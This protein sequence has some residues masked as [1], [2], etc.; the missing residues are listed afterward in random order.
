[1]SLAKASHVIEPKET[2]RE[3]DAS[4]AGEGEDSLVARMVRNLPAM[5]ETQVRS[6]GQE[7]PLE[8]G[9]TTHSSILAWR[10]PW[11][12]EPGGLKPTGCRE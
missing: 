11:T 12:E 9:M 1:M 2:G 8:K 6:L 5:Q 3:A 7:H 10:I 4:Q